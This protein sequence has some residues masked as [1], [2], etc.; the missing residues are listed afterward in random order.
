VRTEEKMEKVH[1]KVTHP[2]GNVRDDDKKL[3]VS[4]YKAGMHKVCTSMPE[5]YL[6]NSC[7]ATGFM[8]SFIQ[9]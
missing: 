4:S 7:K 3:H 2:K 8:S 5:L 9:L 6:H 1:H